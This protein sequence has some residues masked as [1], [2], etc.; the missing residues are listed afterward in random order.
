MCPVVLPEVTDLVA[1]FAGPRDAR[2]LSRRWREAATR[3]YYQYDQRDV[4]C[5]WCLEDRA[6]YGGRCR[7]D[8]SGGDGHH[9]SGSSSTGSSSSSS[10]SSSGDSEAGDHLQP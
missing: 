1:L 3:A 4:L 6:V 8:G 2:C 10:S 5:E 9:G 7:C